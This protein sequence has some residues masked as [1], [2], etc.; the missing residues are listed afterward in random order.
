ML[1][2][3]LINK[4]LLVFLFAANLVPLEIQTPRM[5]FQQFK[6]V[7]HWLEEA[8]ILLVAF[9]LV[10][11]VGVTRLVSQAARYHC[12]LKRGVRERLRPPPFVPRD[13]A[14]GRLALLAPHGHPCI[15]ESAGTIA[16]KLRD[17]DY[18][19]VAVVTAFIA[20][21]RR[22]NKVLNAAVNWREE[23][24]LAEAAE[25]DARLTAAR[26]RQGSV[27][28]PLPALPP[29]LGVPCSVKE[30]IAVAGLRLTAGHVGRR[31]AP[32]SAE[33]ATVGAE[34]RAQGKQDPTPSSPLPPARSW[35]ACDRRAS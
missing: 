34:C 29:F 24:A 10:V 33:D 4:A 30:S 21:A 11:V 9:T 16:Q 12:C 27:S 26:L 32:P 1:L 7:L 18:T 2:F 8:V 31:N 5:S 25:A 35:P 22:V 23:E 19:S 15:G 28:R 13:L 6:N 17:G 14:A 20:Q 3:P